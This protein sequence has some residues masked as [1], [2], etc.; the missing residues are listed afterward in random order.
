MSAQDTLFLLV[1]LAKGELLNQALS[2][3]AITILKQQQLTEALAR[4]LPTDKELYPNHLEIASKSGCVRGIWHDAAL[5][6]HQ[7]KPYYALVIFSHEASDKSYSW[8]QE[9]MMTIAR[10]SRAIYQE[11][12]AL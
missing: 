1:K 9:G 5:I 11:L 8:E 3:L 10:L 7:D 2:E 6:Y 4:Y 12:F